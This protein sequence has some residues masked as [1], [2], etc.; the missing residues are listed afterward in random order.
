MSTKL[1]SLPTVKESPDLPVA[2]SP[3]D[4]S[5][6]LVDKQVLNGVCEPF[7][8]T[9]KRSNFIGGHNSTRL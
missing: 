4:V 8:M 2:L 3:P 6:V 7:D 9:K 1:D 5:L